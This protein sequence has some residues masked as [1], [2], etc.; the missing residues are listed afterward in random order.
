MEELISKK[1]LLTE[2]D[3]S[4]GQLYRW[5]RK[6]L[7]PEEWFMK[8]STYT[9]HETFFPRERIL[10][11]IQQIL[12]MKDG[13]SLDDLADKFSS[14]IPEELMRKKEDLIGL[15]VLH[16]EIIRLYEEIFKGKEE[17][18]FQDI[19]YMYISEDLL[20]QGNLSVEDLSRILKMLS[21]QYENIKDKD[22]ALSVYRRFGVTVSLL[23]KSGEIF[24]SDQVPIVDNYSIRGALEKLK[25]KL[26]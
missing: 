10:E 2:M 12:N 15:G 16:T 11:R 19:L 4:Y 6:K 26:I 20:H 1:D 7:I 14:D 13:A 18:S 3:I 24:Y 23:H 17:Y 25:L 5:K 22:P 9:G 8:K 21:D